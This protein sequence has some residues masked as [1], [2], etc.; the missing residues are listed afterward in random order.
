MKECALRSIPAEQCSLIDKLIDDFQGANFFWILLVLLSFLV[1]NISRTIKWNMLLKPLGFNP[2]F[3]NTFLSILVGYFANLG[4]PRMG[5]VIRAGVL[6]KYEHIAP[7]KV[8]GTIVV[9]RIIDVICLALAFCLALFFEYNKIWAFL[10]DLPSRNSGGNGYKQLLL[11][12]GTGLFILLALGYWFRKQ[13][14]QSAVFQKVLSLFRGLWEGLLT[15]KHLEKPWLF[16]FH[17][18]FIWFLYFL[19]TWLGF[20]AF[21]PTAHLGLQAALT[22]FVF[23]SLGIVIPSPGGMGTFHALVIIA[24]TTF[25]SIKGDD[26]FSI[27]NIIFFSVSIG[28]NI[29]LGLLSLILLPILNRRV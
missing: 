27:A 19:M 12:A 5:E 29:F 6:S 9:D 8:L 16:I 14:R 28:F 15:V 4:L 17:S 24:L 13:I 7:E 18:L 23:G 21:G 3:Y 25:Y 10:S 1:S 26:A 22:V 20:K 2:K 11:I